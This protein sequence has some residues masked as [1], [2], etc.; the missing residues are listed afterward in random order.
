M[1]ISKNKG[2][3]KGDNDKNK[4]YIKLRNIKFWTYIA[5]VIV[6]TIYF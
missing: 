1:T 4:Q 3:Q 6:L 5:Y 2:M